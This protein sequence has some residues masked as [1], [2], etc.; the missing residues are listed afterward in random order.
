MVSGGRDKTNLMLDSDVTKPRYIFLSHNSADKPE[1]IRFAEVLVNRPLAKA[2]NLQVWLDKNNLEHGVQ[3]TNQ[4]ASNINHADTCAFLLFMPREPVR[5]YVEYEIGIAL[6]RHLN[7]KNA[8][9]RFP[10][11]PVYPGARS[12]RVGLPEA[13]RTFNYREYVYDDV[14]QIDA[15]IMDAIGNISSVGASSAGDSLLAPTGE[16]QDGYDVW[17]SWVLTWQG[18]ELQA[19]DDGRN[20]RT[21]ACAELPGIDATPEQLSPLAVWLLGDQIIDGIKGRVRILTDD[22]ELAL[23]PWHRLPHPQTGKPLLDYTWVVETGAGRSRLPGFSNLALYTPLLVIPANQKGI[24][25]DRHCSLVQSYLE[26]YLDIHSLVPRIKTPQALRRELRLH[27]PDLLY[28]YARFEDGCLQLDA[29]TDGKETLSLTMLGEWLAKED[30]QP[31]VVINLLGKNKGLEDY[32]HLLVQHSRLLWLQSTFRKKD[33]N[34]ADLE[35]NLAEVMEQTARDGDLPGLIAKQSAPSHPKMQSFLW[36]NGKTPQLPLANNQQQRARQLRAALLKVMLG[37][38]ALKDQMA[39]SIQRHLN[40]RVLL[41]TYAVT[42]DAKACPHDVPE[43]IRQRLQ[44]DDPKNSLTMVQFYFHVTIAAEE[45]AQDTLDM[46]I[47]EGILHGSD[48]VEYILN[49]ELERRGLRQQECCIALNWLFRVEAGQEDAV[50][51]WLDTWG[52]AMRE[53]FAAVRLEKA[54]LVNAFCLEVAD[55]R[56]AQTVQ[57]SANK[58]LRNLRNLAGCP[59]QPIIHKDALGKLEADELNDFLESNQR[60]WYKELKLPVHKIDPWAFA[61]WVAEQTDGLFEETVNLIWKQYQH[62]YQEYLKP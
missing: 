27:R 49:R 24:V 61:E 16:Q 28:I 14:Q 36:V 53:Y 4:F 60:Y 5:A 6:D 35:K 45:D 55:E 8:G 56:H 31:V 52:T 40:Q 23:L 42:G 50:P 19:E 38:E 32:P 29:G 25:G 18:N 13:I 15:I 48:D 59:M 3:Y 46:A 1:L 10:I 47:S 20:L 21:L 51:G 62:D 33:S 44:Y 57:A 26:A 30:L 11:L 37:R 58:E 12:G 41:A 39:G 34:W 7:D 43:Q 2:H 9:K 17:L 54:I 22:P